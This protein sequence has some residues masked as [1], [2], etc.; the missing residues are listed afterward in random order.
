MDNKIWGILI[1]LGRG[2]WGTNYPTHLEVDKS[3]ASLADSAVWISASKNKL[4]KTEQ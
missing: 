1:H 4:D 3:H 2:M